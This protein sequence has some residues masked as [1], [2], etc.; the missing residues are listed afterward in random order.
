MKKLLYSPFLFFLLISW[1]AQ[2][3]PQLKPSIG[4]G[5]EPAP[6]EPICDIPL[7]LDNFSFSGYQEG[8]TIPDFNLF[9][10][11]GNELDLGESMQDGK[12]VLLIS[13]SYTCFVFR[14][15][16]P[17]INELQQQF[18]DDLNIYI[19]YTVEAHPDGVISPYYGFEN[20]GSA[21]INEGVLY[22]QPTT[23]GERLDIVEDMLDAYQ[24]DVPVYIDGPCNEW[25]QNF[26]P[27]PNNA[28]LISPEGQVLAKH[29]W[30]DKFPFDI[31]CDLYTHLGLGDPCS[32]NPTPGSFD[33]NMVNGDTLVT[34]Y[35]GETLFLYGDLQNNSDDPVLI[36]IKRL[37]EDVPADWATSLCT[38]VCL[39]PS[40]DSTSVYLEPGE[41]LIYT[42]YFYTS[43]LPDEGRVRMGFRNVALSQNK[44]FQWMYAESET[45]P[46]STTSTPAAEAAIEIGPNPLTN[47][48]QLQLDESVIHPQE[49]VLFEVYSTD[50]KLLLSYPLTQGTSTINLPEISAGIYPYFIRTKTDILKKGKLMIAR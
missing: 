22:P 20:V 35:A 48:L 43:D 9:D 24:I 39:P 28:T 7:Y 46:V 1:M 33:F 15:K 2:A 30:F 34:G 25:W 42:M 14:G 50:G 45:N 44:F 27:A 49:E 16:T 13:S 5:P 40:T 3:Q 38:D 41:N 47:Y 6:S 12:P 26:G 36:E 32:N 19:V 29:P 17:L 18:G 23:Y 4:I 11:N 37:I 21:N 8:D 10:V 31:Y